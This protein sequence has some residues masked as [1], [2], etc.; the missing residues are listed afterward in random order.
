[1]WRMCTISIVSRTIKDFVRVADDEEHSYFR[2]V[3]SV[4]AKRMAAQ[5]RDSITNARCNIAGTVWGAL[6][7]V[8]NNSLAV[9]ECLGGI[10]YPHRSWRLSAS[11]TTSSDTNLP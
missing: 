6:P 8:F 10:T 3:G 7:Q 11:A 4:S 9:R 1:V 2:V 5:L